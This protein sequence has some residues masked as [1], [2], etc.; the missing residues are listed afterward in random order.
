MI[1]LKMTNLRIG[2]IAES[3]FADRHTRELVQWARLQ[4]ALA[5]TLVIVRQTGA[6]H[7]V[8]WRLLQAVA[9]CER[10]LLR[11]QGRERGAARR[12]V[13]GSVANIVIIDAQATAPGRQRL[14]ALGLDLLVQCGPGLGGAELAPLVRLGTLCIGG[15]TDDLYRGGPHF[16]WECYH[17]RPK[18]G[19]A[20]TL[21]GADGEPARILRQ[22]F[23]STR[24][25]FSLNEYYVRKKSLPHLKQLLL[26]IA[27]CG[28]LP[29]PLAMRPFSGQW[30]GGPTV[31]QALAYLGKLGARLAEKGMWR[32]VC[33]RKKWEISFLRTSW[34]QAMLCHHIRAPAPRG[35]YWADPFLIEQGGKTYCFVEDYVWRT[36]RGH[37]SVLEV[38]PDSARLLGPCLSEPFHLSFPFMFR[39]HGELYMCPESAAARQIRVYRCAQFPTL[40]EPAAVLMDQVSAADTMLFERDGRWWMLTS[41]DHSGSDDFC[42][43]LYAFWS[44]S[45]LSQQWQPHPCNPLL[46]DPEGGRNAGLIIEGKN[47]YRMAQKQGYD[48]Y[49]KGILTYLITELSETG[50]AEQLVSDIGTAFAPG[51]L[52]VHHMSSNGRITVFDH[53]SRAL[54]A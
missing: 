12:D 18:T 11:V 13:S 2:L 3:T 43:E 17:K 16:F 54:V 50:Y 38:G 49:G 10:R 5:L 31:L 24:Y 23:F 26:E 39:Y 53:K 35:R 20:I 41:M 48:E 52:G 7:R 4:P 25:L 46:I 21:K 33:V 15:D 34:R 51:M 47:I 40:W 32:A 37:I 9:A 45:P 1:V 44:D 30:V 36:A 28:Q 29:A 19:F 14:A 8:G 6:A 22:G 42:S 27:A